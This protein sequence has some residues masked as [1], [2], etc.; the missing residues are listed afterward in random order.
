MRHA[1]SALVVVTFIS[2]GS[3]AAAQTWKEHRPE[4]GG[5]VVEM[6]GEPKVQW[7][8][9][10]TKIGDIKTYIATIEL[11]RIAFVTMYSRY[12]EKYMEGRSAET[13]FEGGRNG[14]VANVKGKL[15]TETNITIS[16]FPGRELMIDTP[17]G[18]L[19]MMRFFLR[20]TTIIQA[21]V[22]G[23]AG[24]ESNADARRFLNSLQSTAAK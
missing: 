22:G 23:P 2:A 8:D 16:N 17:A 24:V 11:G 20:G 21:I 10:P 14:A 5:Y 7:Q 13:I 12:P 6:P 19:M 1:L 4:G 18:Q 9:V 15:R 3:Q